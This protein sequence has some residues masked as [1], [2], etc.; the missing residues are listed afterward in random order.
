MMKNPGMSEAKY[1]E[2]YLQVLK[3][4]RKRNIEMMNSQ[5]VNNNVRTKVSRFRF[6]FL[7]F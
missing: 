4:Q 7:D 3:D 6:K 2:N 5:F 1:Q